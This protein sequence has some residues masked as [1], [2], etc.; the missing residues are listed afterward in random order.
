MFPLIM[1]LRKGLEFEVKIFLTGQHREM[2]GGVLR[3]F[4]IRADY[5]LDIMR[6]GQ[7]LS[8]ISIGV[9]SGA[10]DVI[11]EC[12]PDLVFVVGDTA[13]AYFGA[14]AAFYLKVPVCH[15][16]AGLRSFDISNPFP[17]EMY[18]ASISIMAEVNFAP[19]AIA[20]QNLCS[21]GRK[22]VYTVGNTVVDALRLTE[23]LGSKI[24]KTREK[25][26]LFTLHRR[27]T[28]GEGHRAIFSAI[29]KIAQENP[30]T[31]IL[32][33]MHKN[34]KVRDNAISALSG[35]AGILLTEPLSTFD[36][37]EALRDSYIV[38]TDSGGVSEEAAALRIPALI[39]RDK[40]ERREAIDAGSQ[41]LVGKDP[42]SIINAFGKIRTEA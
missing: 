36:F 2:I 41:M 33:P 13:S 35:Q 1:E 40:T 42:E 8:D 12:M 25:R 4:G 5:R 39:A 20:A 10:M 7:T 18:R 17:E 32:Y 3:H 19:T 29:R 24:P 22:N 27:E 38:I 21:E 31:E 11:S 28:Q 6:I 37:H 9:L 14:L 15:L 26:I 34:P 23:G 16:E 30:D